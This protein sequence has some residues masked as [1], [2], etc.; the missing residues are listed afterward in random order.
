M[1]SE[2]ISNTIV[3]TLILKD[4][5]YDDLSGVNKVFF[6]MDISKNIKRLNNQ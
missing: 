6:D 2:E 3:E 1:F 4:Y 5:E